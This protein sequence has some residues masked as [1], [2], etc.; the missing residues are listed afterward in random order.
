M[1]LSRR[2]LVL[3]LGATAAGAM[4]LSFGLRT[5]AAAGGGA[6]LGNY[7][8]LAPDGAVTLLARNPDMGQGAKS[9][10]PMLIAE[11]LDVDWDRVRV[12]FAPADAKRFESQYAGGSLATPDN[13]EPM[14]RVGA[15]ARAVLV[16]AAA[17]RLK[18]DPAILTTAHGRV[19]HAAS[20]RSL[21]YGDLAAE[22]ARLPLPDPKTLKLKDPKDFTILG[23]SH[24]GVDTPAIL[25]GEPIFGIDMV[26]PGMR[27]AV[28]VKS[29]VYGAKLVS[30][31]LAAARSM[32]GV[33]Q[34][35]AVEGI[36]PPAGAQI[37]LAPG[38][39][40]GIAIVARNWWQAN[41]ARKALNAV[42]D[43]GFGAAHDSEVY[44][45]RA[46]ELLKTPGEVQRAKGD[47]DAA[48][49]SAHRR[50]E[51][52]YEAPFLAHLTL[53][54]QNCTVSPT[55]AGL[56][57]WAPTQFP[58]DGRDAVAKTL[59]LPLE[60]VTV[61]MR[62]CGGGFGRRIMNDFMV[63]AAVI[64]HRAK[65][66][67]KLLWTRTD[68]IGHDYYR[69]GTYQRLTAGLDAAGRVTAY[70][71]HAVSFSRDGKLVDGGEID[72]DAAPGHL[73]ESSRLRRSLI[74]T[75][76]STGWLRA[77]ASNALSFIHES[78]WDELAHAAGQDPIAFRLA[79]LR[80][81][82]GTPVAPP[83]EEGEPQYD[84]RRMIP[85]LELVRQR[86]GWG[87]APLP[88]GVGLGVAA[89]F[90]HRG[91]FAEVAKVRVAP[92]GDWKVEKV[93]VVGDVGGIILNPT[94]AHAQVEGAVTDGI[95]HMLTAIRF[96]KGRAAQANLNDL[97]LMRM[98]AAP[99]VDV[100]FHLTDNPPTGLGEPALPP[101]IPAVANAV[102]AACGARVR[103][104]PMTAER[105]QAARADGVKAA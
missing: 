65:V 70:D 86:S 51:A 62:R 94:T 20:G 48:L 98:S 36:A 56:E 33:E 45:R 37:G 99:E 54:P 23:R 64:A 84:V 24:I 26:L 71:T 2:E 30:A 16:A 5:Q 53:E 50:L 96:E 10:L 69:P 83:T 31:D 3:S 92:S 72:L 9:L 74:P 93:W 81:R 73:A 11:E 85:V 61:H 78:F 29:P 8:T 100:H 102:F 79:H 13:W 76:A 68:D 67:V 27:H 28:Y 95:G 7:V 80:A 38:I 90:S 52:V 43:D 63:E 18:V 88:A 89:Y 91:Y 66:P 25:A 34:V 44:D 6:A 58:N 87:T 42:W 77:P 59:G 14:R 40:P 101:V 46:A 32:P 15:A 39:A 57:I 41:A 103:T 1:S 82:L 19:I 22:A 104:L 4:V 75:I 105:I 35:F 97:T 17:T 49:T 21:A 12:E 47:V 60:A 55:A